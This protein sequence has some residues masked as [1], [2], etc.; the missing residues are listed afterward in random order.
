MAYLVIDLQKS[1]L[2]SQ[3]NTTNLLRK[4]FVV[5]KKLKLSD[6]ENWI[7]LELNGYSNKDADIPDY[8]K[9][10]G[11]LKGLNP[12]T[13]WIPTLLNVNAEMQELL[14]TRKVSDPIS[15]LEFLM[16]SKEESLCITYP[17]AV[18]RQLGIM[19]GFQTKYQLFVSKSQFQGILESVRNVI[20]NW[21]LELECDGILGEEMIFNEVEKQVAVQKNY[22]VN[23]F[24]G[25]VSNSQIQQHS[26]H[27]KQTK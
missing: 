3:I 19:F 6:F 7:S 16:N 12:L 18:E 10:F 2:D 22:T 15:E 23:N 4:A 25:D 20:L 9:V 26:Q 13:G 8:R 21:A 27:C 17:D 14:L 24:Y 5:A 11:Q 1:A